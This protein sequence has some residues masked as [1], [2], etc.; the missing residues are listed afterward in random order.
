[1]MKTSELS[2]LIRGFSN[3]IAPVASS[4]KTKDLDLIAEFFA[5]IP[6]QDIKTFTKEV[7]VFLQERA[8]LTPAELVNG[9]RLAHASGSDR[10]GMLLRIKTLKSKELDVIYGELGWPRTGTAAAKKRQLE[11]FVNGGEEPQAEDISE[12]IAFYE[13]L[14]EEAHNLEPSEIERRFKA[15]SAL[16]LSTLQALSEKVGLRASSKKADMS[17]RLLEVPLGNQANARRARF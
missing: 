17:K 6:D 9:I 11:S 8:P 3:A 13:K 10:G 14:C 7:A 5:G 4:T 12:H 16:P 2:V 15:V 1:M